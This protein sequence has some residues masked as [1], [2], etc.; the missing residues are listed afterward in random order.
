MTLLTDRIQELLTSHLGLTPEQVSTQT[1]DG[2]LPWE[3]FIQAARECDE[4][5]TEIGAAPRDTN[6]LRSEDA[7]RAYG[8]HLYALV[9]HVKPTTIIETGVQ[10]GMST[11]CLLWALHR[12]RHGHLHSIDSGPT[13]S[14]GS[15]A[16]S[17]HAT[18][19]GVPGRDI[20]NGL[21]GRW[22]LHLGLS[23][24][25]LP[26]VSAKVGTVDMFWHDSDHS[27]ENVQRE[28]TQVKE[29][30][31]NGGYACMH[32]YDGQKTSLETDQRFTLVRDRSHPLLRLWKK[33]A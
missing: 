7:F 26:K 29:H 21:R 15:H 25:L 31:R 12:N 10:N 6:R 3:A 20:H 33:N 17:W 11:E 16:S 1:G 27:E 14:D 32:D 19:D 30:L 23:V 18:R 28:F 24:D 8:L 2:I 22:T 4:S 13:S 5:D 9:R